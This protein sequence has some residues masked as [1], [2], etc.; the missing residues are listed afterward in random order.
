MWRKAE[1]S[2]PQPYLGAALVF[3]ASCQTV[4]AVPSVFVAEGAGIEPAR[5][6]RTGYGLASRRITALPT[7][8]RISAKMI[9]SD[10]CGASGTGSNLRPPDYETGALPSELRRL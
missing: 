5:P 8:P 2:N 6:V 4:L 10:Y 9:G 1:E 7:F 3:E